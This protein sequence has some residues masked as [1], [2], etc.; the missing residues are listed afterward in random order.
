MAQIKKPTAQFRR[1]LTYHH[2][3][4]K[5]ALIMATDEILKESGIEGFSLRDAA[6]RAGVSPGAPAHHFGNASGLLTE[7]AILGYQELKAYLDRAEATDSPAARLRSLAAQYV[8][9]ALDHPGRFRLMFRKDLIN[10]SDERYR[11]S[12]KVALLCFAD[13][14]AARA[15]ISRQEMFEKQDFSSVLA[16]WATAHG[17]AHLAL[18]EKMAALLKGKDPRKDFLQRLLPSILQAQWPD[19]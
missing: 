7:V 4:L 1:P 11:E 5:A 18:E 3:E 12:S 16:V 19:K 17:I 15:G 9:F 13:A 2:G 6:R 14:A 8:C 10:R